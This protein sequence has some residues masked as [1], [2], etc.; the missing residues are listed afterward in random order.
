MKNK[1]IVL[2]GFMGS[3]KSVVA[4]SLSKALKKDLICTDVLIEE[5]EKMSIVEIFK[6][7]G[8]PYFR[9]LEKDAIKALSSRKD[10]IIDC[11]GGVVLDHENVKNLK[12]NGIV[13]FLA[14]SPETIYQRIQN[15]KN[16]P[17]LNVENP[18]LKIKELLKKRAPFYSQ[19][20]Y[21][22]ETDKKTV[23]QVTREIIKIFSHE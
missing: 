6:K 8:E 5:K 18:L 23:K 2:T 21:A 9:K 1:N 15:Q 3:G 22:V 10:L 17:L 7:L 11:G 14:A 4:R 12:Q 19:A 20:D 13:F 16:R